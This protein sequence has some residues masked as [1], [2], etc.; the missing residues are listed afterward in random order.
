MLQVEAGKKGKHL[1]APLEVFQSLGGDEIRCRQNEWS[2][3]P[4]LKQSKSEIFPSFAVEPAE[5][6]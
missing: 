5:H 1:S 6:P 3:W 2:K 4:G